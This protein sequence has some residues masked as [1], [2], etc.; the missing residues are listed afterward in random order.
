MR[1]LKTKNENDFMPGKPFVY[2]L[3]N[4]KNK[5]YYFGS[6]PVPID[7]LD[8]YDTSSENLELLQ[9]ISRGEVVRYILKTFETA[10][11]A[12]EYEKYLIKSKNAVLDTNSYNQSDVIIKDRE[13]SRFDLCDDVAKAILKT[14]S[15]QDSIITKYDLTGQKEFKKK[16]GFLKPGSYLSTIEFFQP[17]DVAVIQ[18]HKNNMIELID[19]YTG[20]FEDIAKYKGQYLFVVILKN[21]LYNGRKVDLLIS[22]NHTFNA[23]IESKY[24]YSMNVLWI[25][26]DVHSKWSDIEMR[27]IASYLNP[28]SQSVIKEPEDADTINDCVEILKSTDGDN[29][30]VTDYLNHTGW[31]TKSKMS[32]KDRSI[33]A[34]KKWLNEQSA[35]K[36]FIQYDGNTD[37]RITK[38][39]DEICTNKDTYVQII[40]SGKLSLGDVVQKVINKMRTGE[41]K[42]KSITLLVYHP[43]H[44]KKE[45]FD[46]KWVDMIDAWNWCFDRKNIQ[47]ITYE[48][49]PH[50]RNE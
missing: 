40:S 14:R 46:N 11:D 7:S 13:S 22:G 43:D 2:K 26:E 42:C 28:K 34:Y 41:T 8:E 44:T 45:N 6:K 23:V 16:K 24:A 33:R 35:P 9:A 38:K 50:L 37:P 29:S 32:I 5:K 10:A 47:Y 3:L 1:L 15:Y 31:L 36:N 20:D 12:L 48:E 39:Y 18:S 17:R 19:Q 30:K 21:R 49:M 25:D 4:I 27:T